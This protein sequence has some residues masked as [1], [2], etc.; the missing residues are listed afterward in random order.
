MGAILHGKGG[1]ASWSGGGLALADGELTWVAELTGDTADTT[2]A[3]DAT[4]VG[5]VGTF[6]SWTATVTSN[7]TAASYTDTLLVA[8]LG[9]SG[10]LVLIEGAASSTYTGTAFLVG[11]NKS[12]DINGIFEYTLSFQGTGALVLS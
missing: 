2:S 5:R 1:S 6:I 3:T 10:S 11:F 9:A 8:G 4:F 12:M 7:D